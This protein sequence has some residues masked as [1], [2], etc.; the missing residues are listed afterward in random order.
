MRAPETPIPQ[1]EG[2]RCLEGHMA[3]AFCCAMNAAPSPAAGKCHPS[4]LDYTF[5]NFFHQQLPSRDGFDCSLFARL[6]VD[7]WTAFMTTYNP[8]PDMGYSLSRSYQ[9]AVAEVSK[10]RKFSGNLT[11]RQ[12]Q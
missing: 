7:Q 11:L 3:N 6:R 9:S 10:A 2:G 4:E 8:N 5:R 1:N 12:L